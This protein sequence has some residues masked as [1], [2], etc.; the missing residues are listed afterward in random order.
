MNN[1]V[2]NGLYRHFK[3]EICEVI[4]VARHSETLEPMVIYRHVDD[5]NLWA[6]PL[7]MWHDEIPEIGKRFERV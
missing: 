6:R 7:T 5:K 4:G 2:E 3:G 1:V